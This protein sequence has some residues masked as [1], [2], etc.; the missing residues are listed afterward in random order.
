MKKKENGKFLSFT[1]IR[2]YKDGILW[3]A[4]MAGK[5]LPTTF[6]EEIKKYLKFYKKEL[7]QAWKYGNTDE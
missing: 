1:N 6:Y 5:W 4:S 2:K 7:V 3:A